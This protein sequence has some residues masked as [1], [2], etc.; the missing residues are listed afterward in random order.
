M[1]RGRSDVL[2]TRVRW[3]KR[4]LELEA[5]TWSLS[6]REHPCGPKAPSGT[7]D[8][9]VVLDDGRRIV[10]EMTT[11]AIGDVAY[12]GIDREVDPAS[13]SPQEHVGIDG[14]TSKTGRPRSGHQGPGEPG[15][16]TSGRPLGP[17]RARVRPDLVPS[18][19]SPTRGARPDGGFACA[20]SG[21]KGARVPRL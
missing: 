18:W 16:A 7:H 1:G 15:G 20:R 21:G 6:S 8:F 19:P 11:S 14:A 12:P 5:P 10:L 2:M 4:Q 3:L 17:R 9:D 13:S